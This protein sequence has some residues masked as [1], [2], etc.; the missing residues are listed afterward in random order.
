M[1]EK[2]GT[3][4]RRCPCFA[5]DPAPQ[6]LTAPCRKYQ[7]ACATLE[8]NR[9]TDS[10]DIH[11]RSFLKLLAGWRREGLRA[12][13]RNRRFDYGIRSCAS[14]CPHWR[15]CPS[16]LG[17]RDVQVDLNA[18]VGESFGR[19]TLGHDVD[20][21][22]NVTSASIAC[23]YHAGDPGVMRQAVRMSKDAGVAIGAHPGLP[24]LAGFGR[25][26]MAATPGEVAD[27]VLYQI[28]AL[29]AIAAAEGVRLA[30]VKA[31]GALYNMAARDAALAGAIAGA[32]AAFDPAL[33]LIGP[34]GSELLRAATAAGLPAA[35]EGFADR[36]YEPDGSLTPRTRPGAV[37]DRADIVVERA[38]RMVRLGLVTATDG[39][40][41]TL[42]VDTICIHGD[43]PGAGE[44]SRRLRDGLEAAGIS[45]RPLR[46]KHP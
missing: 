10:A 26:E 3:A 17:P 32:A 7:A 25:R 28:G 30:H 43:T 15:P 37:L 36:S 38:I 33:V 27:F 29:S 12:R 24:D 5:D 2:K 44:L 45:V 23:G 8:S 41:L 42:R 4:V 20:V 31:H 18:D 11:F 6:Q 39:S 14:R 34:P 16:K 9:C 1:N 35:G 19:W 21:I 46:G 13:R 40:E 22:R